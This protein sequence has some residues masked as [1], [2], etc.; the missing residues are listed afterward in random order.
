MAT[1]LGDPDA[2]VERLSL[3]AARLKALQEEAVDAMAALELPAFDD[4]KVTALTPR[5]DMAPPA[6]TD[7]A[8]ARL[9][10]ATAALDP[11]RAELGALRTRMDELASELAARG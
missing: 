8:L 11:M 10:A 9:Q 1:D 7:A 2:V 6:R 3:A 5:T 4:V